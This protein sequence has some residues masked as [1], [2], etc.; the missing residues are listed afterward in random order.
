MSYERRLAWIVGSIEWFEGLDPAQ[1]SVEIPTCPA[2]SV[3]DLRAHLAW[4]GMAW[5]TTATLTAG[6]VMNRERGLEMLDPV[7]GADQMSG[8][9]RTFASILASH[10][11]DDECF[12]PFAAPR[13]FDSWS[14]HAVSELLLHRVDAAQAVGGDA[15]TDVDEVLCA[16]SWVVQVWLPGLAGR[17]EVSPPSGTVEVVPNEG[18]DAIRVGSGEPLATLTGPAS[19]LLQV[20]SGRRGVGVAEQRTLAEWWTGILARTAQHTE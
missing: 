9:L 12:Y 13:C 20:V 8:A 14:H 16:L 18:G 6:T 3:D 5:V 7:R 4:D 17:L 2:W 15:S 10:D 1:G 11:P 19:D